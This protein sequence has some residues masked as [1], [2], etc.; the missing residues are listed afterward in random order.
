MSMGMARRMGEDLDQ[1]PA[2]MANIMK[3]ADMGKLVMMAK[4]CKTFSL[5][6]QTVS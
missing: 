4:A 3:S 2:T 5:G 1:G 6:L